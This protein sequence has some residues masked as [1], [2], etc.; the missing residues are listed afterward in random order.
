[1]FLQILVSG[2]RFFQ[3]NY[4]MHYNLG[5]EFNS[6]IASV[7]LIKFDVNDN[8][9]FYFHPRSMHSVNRSDVQILAFEF[10]FNDK[11]FKNSSSNEK[12]LA[13]TSATQILRLFLIYDICWI[14]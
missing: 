8:L 1:M 6:P 7:F 14:F 5:A 2:P 11:I 9:R 4:K 12:Y 13:A 3:G 10:H